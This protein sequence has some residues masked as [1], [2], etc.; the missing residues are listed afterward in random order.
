MT[1]KKLV[2]E[3]KGKLTT[4]FIWFLAVHWEYLHLYRYNLCHINP[5][6]R[7]CWIKVN[8]VFSL[9]RKEWPI[10]FYKYQDRG[11]DFRI[12]AYYVSYLILISRSNFSEN[13]DNSGYHC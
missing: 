5:N 1:F 7:K 11:L 3:N 6:L 9:T 10:F 2:L 8:P 12:F 13:V 4:E